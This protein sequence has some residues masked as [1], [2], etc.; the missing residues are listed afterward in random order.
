MDL[1]TFD[2][3]KLIAGGGLEYLAGGVVPLRIGYRYDDGHEVHSLTGGIGY[4]DAK[5]GADLSIAQEI[6]GGD[7]TELLL[8]IRYHVQ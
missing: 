7:G 5:F 3:A 8:G 1:T 2:D 6:D 4:V